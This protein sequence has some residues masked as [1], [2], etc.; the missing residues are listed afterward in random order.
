MKT[1][2]TSPWHTSLPAI[3]NFQFQIFNLQ[4]RRALLASLLLCVLALTP[5]AF[6]QTS[7]NPPAPAQG[8]FTSVE[9]YFTSFYTNLDST[10]GATA[11]GSIWTSVDSIQGAQVPLANSLGVSYDA[12]K[13]LSVESVIRNS[14]VAG[15]I[16][17]AQGGLGLN[18]IVHDT[19]LTLYADGGYG[20]N[21]SSPDGPSSRPYAEFGVRAQKALTAHTFAGLGIGA[22]LPGNR[23]VFSALVGFTF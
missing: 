3:S 7:N 15:T 20:L 4:F 8:F 9:G 17:S 23:Q 1:L 18:V 12:Y 22:Q 14:G 6:S 16:V 19:K 13:S 11:R 2:I 10:F 21:G 5:S